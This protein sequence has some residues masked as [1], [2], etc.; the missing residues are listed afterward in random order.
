MFGWR[1]GS[2]IAPERHKRLAL[3]LFGIFLGQ[4]V[5]YGPSLIGQ[6]ILLPLDILV[7]QNFY[8]PRPPDLE[9]IE[10]QNPTATDQVYVYEPNRHFYS[11]ELK[12][13]RF[14]LWA[15]FQ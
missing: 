11:S 10:A 9:N 13:G 2:T 8:P 14:P 12:A 3:I 15:P 5:L 4:F 7:Q 1:S 6:K